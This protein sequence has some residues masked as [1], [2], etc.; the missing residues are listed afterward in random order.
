MLTETLTTSGALGGAAKS[1]SPAD[2][3]PQWG[4]Q[5]FAKMFAITPRTLRFYE[6]KG[7]ISPDRRSGG[8]VYGAR[9]Y[10]RTERILRAKDMGYS[11]DDIGELFEII[12]GEVRGKTELLRRKTTIEQAVKD[13]R[14]RRK[15]LDS[16]VEE[17]Q[18]LLKRIDS[19]TE[20]APE[21]GVFQHA[22]AYEAMFAQTLIENQAALDNDEAAILKP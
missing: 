10:V 20:T 3:T 7:L 18:I 13:L 15:M 9:D 5:E 2:N 22:A 17:L 1:V 12:D 14:R 8:R 21:D 11:L 16:T 19:Y 6:D 4:I